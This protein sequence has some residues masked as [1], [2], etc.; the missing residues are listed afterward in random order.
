ML[1]RSLDEMKILAHSIDSR[2]WERFREKSRSDNKS[3]SA[4]PD[5]KSP[6][7][8]D[9][10]PDSKTSNNHNNNASKNKPST[11]ASNNNNDNKKSA[12]PAASGS[13][14]ADKLGNDGKLK[15]NERQRRFDNNLCLYCGGVGHKTSDYKKAAASKA[16]ARAAQVQV[17]NKDDLKKA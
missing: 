10:K 9:N 2:Y 3:S 13:S 16:K 14:I 7:K 4:K 17:P 12:T 1:F 8:S 5:N 6:P 15:A 11:T